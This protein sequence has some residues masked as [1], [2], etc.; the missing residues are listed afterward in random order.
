MSRRIQA[1]KAGLGVQC[2][3]S[4]AHPHIPVPWGKAAWATSTVVLASHRPGQGGDSWGA[5]AKFWSADYTSFPQKPTTSIRQQPHPRTHL[6]RLGPG[7]LLPKTVATAAHHSTGMKSGGSSFVVNSMP[8]TS[9]STGLTATTRTTSWKHSPSSSVGM[10]PN[11]GSLA[12]GRSFWR[13]TKPCGTPSQPASLV[14][15][16]LI[17]RL[18]TRALPFM[19]KI[20]PHETAAWRRSHHRSVK[21]S[22]PLLEPRPR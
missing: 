20:G 19:T 2:A 8:P 15:R 13:S 17:H 12:P 22:R 4:L 7:I 6:Y 5:S 14:V 16:Y 3:K 1:G 9:T 21:Y 11:S 10:K 18:P